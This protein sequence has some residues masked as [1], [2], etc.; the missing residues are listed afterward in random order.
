VVIGGGEPPTPMPAVALAAG[1]TVIAMVAAGIATL[2]PKHGLPLTIAYM[3]FFDLP[4]GMMPVSL[5][6]LSVSH[7]VLTLAG[8]S[9][10]GG[11]DVVGAALALAVLGVVWLGVALL[12]IRRL[13][14]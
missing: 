3:L 14:A 12:R 1:T 8:M 7:Q 9:P 13:E 2:V 5:A 11:T 4:V 10:E 6:E